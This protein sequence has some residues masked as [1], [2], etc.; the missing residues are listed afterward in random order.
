[1]GKRARRPSGYGPLSPTDRQLL[2]GPPR[3][4]VFDLSCRGRQKHHA[5]RVCVWKHWTYRTGVRAGVRISVGPDGTVRI[6]PSALRSDNR[7]APPKACDPCQRAVPAALGNARE[8]NIQAVSRAMVAGERPPLQWIRRVLPIGL[9]ACRRLLNRP[10]QVEATPPSDT[11]MKTQ[12]CRLRI[13]VV[14]P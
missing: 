10:S 3:W 13:L 8:S 1:M 11:H 14:E 9:A 7:P 4:I 12:E 5:N 2:R 6:R